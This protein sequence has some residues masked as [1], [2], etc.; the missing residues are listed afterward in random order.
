MGCEALAVFLIR[1]RAVSYVFNNFY[2]SYLLRCD[3]R[4][5]VGVALCIVYS[6]TLSAQPSANIL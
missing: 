5:P 2:F 6:C 4:L 3:L 1:Q